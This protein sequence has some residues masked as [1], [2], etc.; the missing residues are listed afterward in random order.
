MDSPDVDFL[1]MLA[2]VA[3]AETL[4]RFRNGA[5][6]DNKL[7]AAFDPVTEADR[8][9]EQ[10]IVAA[11]RARYAHH[12]VLGEEFG[13]A[14]DGDQ[15][16]V[17]DPI[18]G[19]RAFIAGVPVWGTLIGYCESGKARLGVMSQPFTGERFFADAEAAWLMHGGRRTQLA[20]RRTEEM[21]AATL[22]TTTPRLFVGRALHRFEELEQR[23][24]LTRFGVDCYAFCMLAAGH[25]DLVVETGLKPYDIVA[26]V[27]IIERAGGVITTFAGERPEAGGDVVASATPALHRQALDILNS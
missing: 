24:R 6:V 14:G 8:A 15:L 21:A 16:W 20:V 11:I 5:S 23:A 26:L 12:A 22:F 17:I 7:A 1:L 2:D 4:P 9:A 10:A 25:A 19:T 27:P 18:D 3:D 13:A